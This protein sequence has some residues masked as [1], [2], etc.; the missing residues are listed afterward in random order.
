MVLGFLFLFYEQGNG[1][2]VPERNPPA[3]APAV[4]APPSGRPRSANRRSPG[5]FVGKRP[6]PMGSPEKLL[7]LLSG[8][9]FPPFIPPP[10]RKQG[11]KRCMRKEPRSRLPQSTFPSHGLFPI[12]CVPDA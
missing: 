5:S 11:E 4:G 10:P 7:R 2:P 6:F 3:A 12:C 1:M 9:L 8:F